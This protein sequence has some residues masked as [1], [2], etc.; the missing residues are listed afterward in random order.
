MMMSHH[1]SGTVR[2]SVDDGCSTPTASIGI[3]TGD[4]HYERAEDVIRDADLAMY[5][6]KRAGKARYVVFDA[7]MSV[8]RTGRRR[9]T[10]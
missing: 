4:S 1:T 6:A 5:E 8:P 10:P 3:V 9:L 2:S 7:S